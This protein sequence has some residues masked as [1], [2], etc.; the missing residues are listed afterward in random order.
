MKETTLYICEICGERY[1]SRF[2]SPAKHL[3][4]ERRHVSS[5]D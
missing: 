4:I 5:H 2:V 3:L 1:A